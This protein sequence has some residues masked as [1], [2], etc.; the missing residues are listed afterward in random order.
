V[1]T[2]V[3]NVKYA[4]WNLKASIAAVQ[5]ARQSLDLASSCLAIIDRMSRLV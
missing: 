4:Y 2:T 1:L 5:V 3:R